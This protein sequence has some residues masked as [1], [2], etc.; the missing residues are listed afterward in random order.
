MAS[1][2]VFWAVQPA[3]GHYIP[4]DKTKVGKP[5]NHP[6]FS[7]V[8]REFWNIVLHYQERNQRKKYKKRNAVSRP[9]NREQH[10]RNKREK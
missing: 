7:I 9:W 5:E 10:R 6:A 8:F 3:C 1:I 2:G 4:D